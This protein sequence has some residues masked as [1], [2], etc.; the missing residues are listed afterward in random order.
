MAA[1]TTP[2]FALTPKIGVARLNTTDGI[3]AVTDR[4]GSSITANHVLLFTAGSFGSRIDAIRVVANGTLVAPTAGMIRIW[5][6]ES[7]VATKLALFWEIAVTAAS[8]PS[9]SVIG[10]TNATSETIT[11][12]LIIPNGASIYATSHFLDAAGNQFSIMAR[13]G[14]F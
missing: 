10:F 8:V 5:Y 14:D 12:G 1:N 2:I 11:N 7:A 3:A 13:G 4:T 6:R 9:A